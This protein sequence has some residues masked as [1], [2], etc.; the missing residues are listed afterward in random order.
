M[1]DWKKR[2]SKSSGFW[3]SLISIVALIAI[4]TF[5]V[6]THVNAGAGN[7]KNLTSNQQRSAQGQS[8]QS[9]V[10]DLTTRLADLNARYQLGG[11]ADALLYWES[12]AAWRR[13]ARRYFPN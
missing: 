7:A 5:P 4:S 2:A 11:K 3:I 10:R 9:A 8:R 12:R 1:N 13:C 6:P